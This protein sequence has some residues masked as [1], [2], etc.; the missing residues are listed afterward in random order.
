MDSLAAMP[1]TGPNTNP[2]PKLR[3]ARRP[4][5]FADLPTDRTVVFGILNVTPDSFSDG[6]EYD[7]AETAIGHGLRMFYNGADVIDVGGESTRPNAEEVSA[8]EEQRRVLPVVEALVKAGAVVSV[9]TRNAETARKALDAGAHIINDVSGSEVS[10]DMVA[11]VAQSGAHYVLMHCRGDARTMQ[12]KSKYDDLVAEVVAEIKAGLAKFEAAGVPKDRLIVDP[13]LGFS[14]TGK[15][16]WTLLAH[17]D[18]FENLGHRVLVGAS[19][20]KFL[21]S[22][23]VSAGKAAAPIERD[24]ATTAL[25]ALLAAKRVWGVRVHE[26]KASVDAAK[27]VARLAEEA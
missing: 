17:I 5:R 23:L 22:L 11:A 24:D 4:A 16:N 12:S 15:Q 27:V 18:E 14:K 10:D 25:T 7:T 20:K 3:P 13:G 8:E 26:P 1:G 2:L 21:G 19:R 9:D 6:G